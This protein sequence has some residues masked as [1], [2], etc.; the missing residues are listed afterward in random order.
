ML[1][2]KLQ[3]PQF[4]LLERI[5]LGKVCD[6]LEDPAGCKKGVGNWWPQIAK[7]IFSDAAAEPLCK[8]LSACDAFQSSSNSAWNCDACQK[9]VKAVAE[10]A[11]SKDASK[12]AIET[13]NGNYKIDFIQLWYLFVI[14]SNFQ[15]WLCL[16]HSTFY[17]Q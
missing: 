11:M 8:Q 6:T 13:L 2:E 5:N 4:I 3:S 7:I 14:S 9:D 1:L 16:A 10:I 17:L 12:L 15:S